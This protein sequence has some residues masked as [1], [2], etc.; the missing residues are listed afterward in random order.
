MTDNLRHVKGHSITTIEEEFRAAPDLFKES[1]F[2]R[3]FAAAQATQTGFATRWSCL[4]LA[5]DWG[6]GPLADTPSITP[7][8]R[9]SNEVRTIYAEAKR[10]CNCAKN[11]FRKFR[12][13]GPTYSLR[14][15][16]CDQADPLI[17]LVFAAF[18]FAAA[19]MVTR[20]ET[21][22]LTMVVCG[23]QSLVLRKALLSLR[24]LTRCIQKYTILQLTTTTRR[25]AACPSPVNSGRRLLIK[26]ST[27]RAS[28]RTVRTA[29]WIRPTSFE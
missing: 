16:L 24:H 10:V 3:N 21:P 19:G 28:R 13:G 9:L 7:T 2:Y 27:R 26:S 20:A 25:W 17:L 29:R 12:N 5:S 4:R 11:L 1:D 14:G 8:C 15:P 18:D 22:A 23:A 6:S